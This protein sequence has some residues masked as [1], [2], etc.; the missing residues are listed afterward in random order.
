[1][2]AY[3]QHVLEH[4][5]ALWTAADIDDRIEVQWAMFPTG[6]TWRLETFVAPTSCLDFYHLEDLARRKDGLVDHVFPR[7]N[8]L[9]SWM[10][11]LDS[12]RKAA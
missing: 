2:L 9:T 1:M 5:S 11:L 3:A 12:L 4:A 6:L 10:R 7:W 8:P